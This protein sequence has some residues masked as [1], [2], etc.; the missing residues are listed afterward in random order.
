MDQPKI[1]KASD[2]QVLPQEWGKLVWFASGKLGN[3]A[4]MT[5]GQC[6]LNPGQANPPHSHP[7]CC[8]ILHV[9]RGRIAHTVEGGKDVELGEGDTITIP[10]DFPHR[11]K[12][13]GEGEAVLSIAFSSADRQVKGE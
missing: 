13:I 12:N 2:R 4:E 6:V 9:A 8:E 3:S 10:R 7:N 1:L 11:A 5:L